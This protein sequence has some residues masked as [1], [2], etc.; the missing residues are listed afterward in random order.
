[1]DTEAVISTRS[2]NI[3]DT[4]NSL[5]Y[6]SFY[7]FDNKISVP[8]NLSSHQCH[9]Q[10]FPNG[11]L[12]MSCFSSIGNYSPVNGML[13]GEA[14]IDIYNFLCVNLLPPFQSAQYVDKNESK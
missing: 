13:I 6:S 1:M 4:S 12:C 7:I 5:L 9:F 11:H 3:V 8:I 14:K 10:R 2:T